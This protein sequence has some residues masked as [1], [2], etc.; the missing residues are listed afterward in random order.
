MATAIFL[1]LLLCTSH[2]ATATYPPRNAS[3]SQTSPLS[4]K[5]TE[6]TGPEQET[7]EQLIVE[8]PGLDNCSQELV[9]GEKTDG[10]N[11]SN[12]NQDT[13]HFGKKNISTSFSNSTNPDWLANPIILNVYTA[14]GVVSLLSLFIVFMVYW[15]IPDFKTL[16]GRIVI[17]NV[18]SVTFVTIFLI[19]V[20]NGS[21]ILSE[22]LCTIIGYFGYFSSISMFCWMTIM[23]FDLSYTLLRVGYSPPNLSRCR[24]RFA[25]Y[26]IFGWGSGVF[27]TAGLIVLQLT[28]SAESDFNP[29]IGDQIC[30]ISINGNKLLYLFHLPILITLLINIS[31]CFYL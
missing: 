2:Q 30:F 19:T 28:C 24:I 8:Y 27:M 25:S 29:G 31:I 16:H 9:M 22:L 1:Y 21:D 3:S 13:L 15:Y 18:I 10:L 5:M 6:E 14:A 17:N 4:P 26:S 11:Y 7:P 20:Y 12:I 23:C